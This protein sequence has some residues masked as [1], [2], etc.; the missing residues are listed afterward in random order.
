MSYH[1]TAY[2][3]RLMKRLRVAICAGRLEE[4]VS[5]F[6][7]QLYVDNDAP[8]PLWVLDALEHVGMPTI[9]EQ[10]GPRTSHHVS[11]ETTVDNRPV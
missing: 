5:L 3:M 6:L 8:V 4:E 11:S 2:Q 9:R 1:N 10:F 7:K